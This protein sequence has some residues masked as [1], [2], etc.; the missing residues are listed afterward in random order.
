MKLSLFGR[1]T[2]ALLASAA[3]GLGMTA[4][5]GGTIGYMWV[6][7]QQYNQIAGFKIDDYTGNLTTVPTSPFSSGGAMP[8]SIVV[9]TGGRFVYVIDQ[10]TGGSNTAAG[11]GQAIVEYAVGGDGTLTYQDTYQTQGYVSEWAQ[12]DATGTY[13][14]VLDKYAPVNPST[15]APSTNGA[16]T[17][18]SSD[19]TTGRLSLVT[20]SQTQV[21]NLN[22]YYWNVGVSPS[23]LKVAGSCVFALNQGDQSISPFSVG[24]SGQ[25]TVVQTGTQLLHTTSATS[26]TGNSTYVYV[27]DSNG[28]SSTTNYIYPFT[29]G[30][31]CTLTSVTGGAINQGSFGLG[32]VDPTYTIVDNSGKYLY[33]LNQANTNTTSQV[34]YSS[35]SAYTISSVNGQ[36]APIAGAPYTVGSGPVCMVEDTSNQYIYVSNHNDGTIT[37]KVIDP[38]TGN[39]S[40]LSRGA[41]FTASGE[42]SCL[43]LSGAVS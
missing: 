13:L 23:M 6:L 39:L 10:G 16:I 27:T 19:P 36:L 26:I 25:L 20:N 15:K 34:P 18:F 5:G 24:A 31:S 11:S 40:N 14:M 38:T 32:V 12:M 30:S 37:G 17:V 35:I 7:G 41:T 1:L 22:T 21:N 4:C 3:L 43:V 2:M 42:A 9:K 33:V 28:G 29:I 8:V